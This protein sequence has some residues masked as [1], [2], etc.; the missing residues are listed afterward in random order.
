M[1]DNFMSALAQRGGMG[2][3]DGESEV[4]TIDYY[5]PDQASTD[6]VESLA[7]GFAV[8]LRFWGDRPGPQT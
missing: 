6:V 3:Y 4:I 8:E 7:A 2:H 1:I 5:G